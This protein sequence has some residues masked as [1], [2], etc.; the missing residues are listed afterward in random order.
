MTLRLA[1]LLLLAALPLA[2]AETEAPSPQMLCTTHAD[3]LLVALDEARW[4][5]ATTDFD[6]ALRAR[7]TPAKLKQDYEALPAK[8]GK[9]MGRGRA[10]TA[11]LNGHP[12]VMTPLIF[13]HGLSTA[14]VRCD[15][16]GTVADFKLETTQVMG[17]P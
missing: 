3:T 11:E 14:E 1:T 2:H 7:Y 15:G 8:L 12:V 16:A 4:D 10:H 9:A 6:S 17:T 5:A 13:E